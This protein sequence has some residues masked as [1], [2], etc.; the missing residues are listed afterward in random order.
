M[1]Y[2]FKDG[3]VV[4]QST[5]NIDLLDNDLIKGEGRLVLKSEIILGKK[6]ITNHVPVK[7]CCVPIS[8]I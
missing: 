6:L 2:L 1:Y 8:H 3:N 7:I 4:N 5:D